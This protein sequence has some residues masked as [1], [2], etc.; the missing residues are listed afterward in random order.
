MCPNL[1]FIILYGLDVVD[2]FDDMIWSKTTEA[3]ILLKYA[4]KRNQTG[5]YLWRENAIVLS[6]SVTMVAC[7]E[8]SSSQSDSRLTGFLILYYLKV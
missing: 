6:G 4:I 5:K 8:L 1:N 2:V 3:K 7:T